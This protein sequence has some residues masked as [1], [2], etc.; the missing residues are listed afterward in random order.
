M[1]ESLAE[2]GRMRM[3]PA[4]TSARIRGFTFVELLVVTLVLAIFLTFA[5]VNWG[6]FSGTEKE[7][8]LEIFSMQVALLREEAVSNYEERAIEFDL[9]ANSIR[10]GP[11]DREKGLVQS[12]EVKVPESHVLKDVVIN[13]EKFT[14]GKVFML[15]FPG[16]MTDRVILH[17]ETD[18]DQFFSVLF[19]PL[20]AKVTG[21]NGYTDE[22]TLPGRDNTS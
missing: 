15:F 21:E 11:I 14:T 4:P 7:T 17:F 19:N 8:F 12:R 1:T 3:F 20:T 13:G 9:S 22:I 6:I 5:S 10:L 16:G 2:Q 18:Q